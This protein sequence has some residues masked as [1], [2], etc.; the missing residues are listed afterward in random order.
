M[1]EVA[2]VGAGLGGL[3]LARVLHVHGITSTVYEADESPTARTQ[4]GQLDIHEHNG[5]LALREAGLHDEFRTLIRAG[6]EATRILARDGRVLLDLPDDGTGNRPEVLRGE[7]RRLLLDS[8]PAGT[9]QWAHKL[10]TAT[11][12]GAGR[13]ELTF[14]NGRTVTTEILVGADGAWS[15]VRPLLSAATPEYVGTSMIETYLYDADERHPASAAA[16]GAGAMLATNPG[17]G[18]QAHREANAVLHTY[19]ALSK[20]LD[21]FAGIDFTD[22]PAA[23]ARL[24]AEFSGWAPE[25]TALLTDGETPPVH[26]PLN[27]LPIGHSWP[28]IPGV[29]LLGDAAHLAPPNGEGANLAML[30]GAELGLAIAADPDD[31]EAA[32]TAY[33]ATLFPRSRDEAEEAARDFDIIF[34]PGT[35]DSVLHLFTAHAQSS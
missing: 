13:H 28:R 9:V 5:Q 16:V 6:A 3:T 26:R 11:A 25:L 10:A 1:V 8:L 4:G 22:A 32:L 20:P 19:V 7:L 18:I 30:D 27:A 2:I 21:W 17:K 31:V 23:T 33:E 24:A 14:T 35:P 12:L 29:T 15:R 34:G